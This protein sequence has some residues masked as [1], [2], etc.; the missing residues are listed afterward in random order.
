MGDG[1]CRGLAAAPLH[2][3]DPALDGALNFFERAALDRRQALARAP[4][5]VGESLERDWLVG[6]A[7]RLE[8]APLSV[9]E[10]GERLPERLAPVVE[11]LVVGKDALLARCLVDQPVLP[12]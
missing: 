11:L 3:G 10:H 6:E 5:L 9:I 8:D 2:G 1:H 7:A 12:L 4:E